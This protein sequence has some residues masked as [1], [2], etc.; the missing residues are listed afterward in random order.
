V[1]PPFRR[2]SAKFSKDVIVVAD[3]KGTHRAEEPTVGELVHDLSQQ[4]SELVR[5]ELR[6][7]RAELQQKG[8]HAGIGLGLFSSAGLLAFFGG[9]CLIATAILALALVVPGWV[10]ALVVTLLLFAAAGIAALL[11]RRQ[12]QEATP[13]KPEQTMDNIPK[14]V[15]AVK[16]PMQERSSR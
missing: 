4:I 15:Q 10:A 14:D 1:G 11:G 7:A 12:V 5:E 13:P 16:Q 3:A 6:L 2:Q 9:A 8:K